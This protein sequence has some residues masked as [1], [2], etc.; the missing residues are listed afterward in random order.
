MQRFA[1]L[2][3]KRP[4]L[5][6]I[7]HREGVLTDEQIDRALREWQARRESGVV[8][9]FGQIV[10]MLGFLKAADLTPYVALQKALAA[11]PDGRKRLG[12]LLLENG[13]LRPSQLLTALREHLRSG[14][15]LGQ[16]LIRMGLLRQH[17][18]EILLRFQHQALAV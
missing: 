1:D 12:V 7:L 3:K 4:L 18:L 10:L 15:P 5:A 17:Q 14:L 16:T 6:L 11:P 8:H 2:P 13:L 9:P